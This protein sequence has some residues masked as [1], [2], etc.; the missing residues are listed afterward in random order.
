MLASGAIG[1]FVPVVERA[2]TAIAAGIVVGCF[3]G[4][5]RGYVSARSRKQVENDTL[6][7]GYIGAAIVLGLLLI[8][9]C[10]VYAT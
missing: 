8:D 4:A 10:I 2:A 6:R 7:D 1:F 9:L 5:T 3:A